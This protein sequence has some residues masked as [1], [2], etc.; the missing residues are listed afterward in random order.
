ML[1][2]GSSV[3]RFRGIICLSLSC[4]AAK[5]AYDALF[6]MRIAPLLVFGTPFPE[7]GFDRSGDEVLE[8]RASERYLGPIFNASPAR[9]Y[10]TIVT[11]LLQRVYSAPGGTQDGE[12]KS[13]N[14]LPVELQE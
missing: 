14:G 12:L 5:I 8:T 13:M 6:R 1:C 10:P 2:F 3:R 11:M 4:E 9:L 7:S